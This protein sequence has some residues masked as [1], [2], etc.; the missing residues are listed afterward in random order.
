V[1][2]NEEETKMT[3]EPKI[4]RFPTE[5][6][7]YPYTDKSD[8]AQR[9]RARQYC[10]FLKGE[11]KKPRKSEPEIKVGV[12]SVGYKGFLKEFT[13]IV[14]CPHRFNSDHIFDTI[15]DNY[16]GD[17]SSGYRIAWAPEVSVGVGGSIDYVAVKM[18]KFGGLASLE[19]FVC[20]EFQAA[21]TT[22]TP[23]EAVQDYR[24]TGK[25]NK[26]NYDY[27]INWANEFAKTMMQQVY[28]KA[29]IIEY[30]NK[31]IIF[32]VQDA[33]FRYLKTYYD[34]SGLRK[35][36]DTDSIHFYTFKMKWNKE[37][38]SWRLKLDRKL[39]TNTEGIRKILAGA[40]EVKF[41]TISEF[42]RNIE[43]KLT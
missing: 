14:I 13:P 3:P 6:F 37:S 40:P 10:P 31:K 19:D 24:R 25:F 17:I 36:R 7:G 38:A 27:G 26:E 29:Q 41:P 30:W 20:V 23:W 32:I 11:C 42:I 34:T 28:K 21:G 35:L 5:Y 22:G 43:K 8:I 2:K 4:K 39:S 12:C 15:E 9:A 18:K 16:F 33:G 1:Y